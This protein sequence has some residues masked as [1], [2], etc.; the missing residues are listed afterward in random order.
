[1]TDC[2]IVVIGHVDHGKTALVKALTGIDT[3]RLEEEKRRGLSITAGFA[4]RAYTGGTIDFI[5]APGHADFIRAMVRGASGAQAALLVVCARDGIAA[6][7]VEHLTIA[8]LLGIDRGI[9]V[10]NKCDGLDENARADRI[11][12]LRVALRGTAFECAPVVPCS[13][14]TGEGLDALHSQIGALTVSQAAPRSAPPGPYLP[15]DRVFNIPGRGVVVTGTLLGHGL[16]EGAQVM[17]Y[18]AGRKIP[19]RGLQSRGADCESIAAGTRA[20]VNLRGVA[21]GDI[22]RGD[23]LCDAE[24]LLPASQMDVEIT[25]LPE[26]R[27]LRHMQQV[28]VLIGTTATVAKVRLLD[29]AKHV[30]QPGGRALA[31]LHFDAPLIAYSGQCAVLRH[32]SPAQTFGGAIVLDPQ[33]PQERKR[34]GALMAA[35]EGNAMEIAK[36]LVLQGKGAASLGE[37][38]RLARRAPEELWLLLAAGY[39]RLDGDVI[40]SRAAERAHR[41]ALLAALQDFHATHP[42]RAVAPRSLLAMPD[43]VA[44][45]VETALLAEGLIRREEGGL[46]LACHDPVALLGDDERARMDALESAVARGV[47]IA[48]T[49]KVDQDLL[50]LLIRAGHLV[51]LHNVGLNQS[52]L[53]HSQTLVDAKQRLRAEFP[54]PRWFR[55]GEARAA[56]GTSRKFIVPLLEH[57]DSCG[58]TLR[59][60][61]LRRMASDR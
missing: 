36:V 24:G 61:A 55:T 26:V 32:L 33:A 53:F 11:A 46:A 18:P 8:G 23:V 1:M 12:A 19:V 48:P 43:A 54:P 15:I 17:L 20:A 2:A 16:A 56:L 51:R 60:G 37:I 50:A 29:V 39:Q 57:F 13:A 49:T 47:S 10:L 25:M 40:L 42:L 9:V 45:H 35:S 22:S 34:V 27:L 3:D 14:L 41:S 44:R 38:A 31:R 7:T 21:A 6:Q 4:H 52:V 28:R 59:D 5:D 58:I 30:V